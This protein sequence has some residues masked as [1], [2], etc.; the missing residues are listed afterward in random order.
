MQGAAA[1]TRYEIKSTIGSFFV[2]LDMIAAAVFHMAGW[3][4]MAS[5][6]I[7]F[8]MLSGAQAIFYGCADYLTSGRP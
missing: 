5:I 6:W 7:C 2:T 1:V 8:A 3:E 4:T